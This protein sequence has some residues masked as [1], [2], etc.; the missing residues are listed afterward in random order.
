MPPLLVLITHRASCHSC[1]SPLSALNISFMFHNHRGSERAAPP[2]GSGFSAARPQITYFSA[3]SHHAS[4]CMCACAQTDADLF[5]REH[6]HPQPRS[7]RW[8]A[9]RQSLGGLCEGEC[10]QLIAKIRC[11]ST[12]KAPPALFKYGGRHSPRD[13]RRDAEKQWHLWQV[14][15][16]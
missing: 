4:V 16:P 2:G 9:L 6:T 3:A 10:C 7:N 11:A 5:F 12:P 15:S 1:L 14:L 8:T 13:E